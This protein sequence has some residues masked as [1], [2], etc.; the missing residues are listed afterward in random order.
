[1]RLNVR[2]ISADSKETFKGENYTNVGVERVFSCF[3]MIYR[4]LYSQPLHSFIK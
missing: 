1:M 2:P 3:L 4:L